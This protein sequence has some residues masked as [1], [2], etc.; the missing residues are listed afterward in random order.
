MGRSVQTAF[1]LQGEYQFCSYDPYLLQ[2]AVETELHGLDL[3]ANSLRKQHDK[4]VQ[5]RLSS[6]SKLAQLQDSLKVCFQ[7]SSW[8]VLDRR[9]RCFY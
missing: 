7:L 1:N 8:I 9:E 3:Q 5:D 4:L 2:V 6:T